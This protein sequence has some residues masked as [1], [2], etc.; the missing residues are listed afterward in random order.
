[1]VIKPRIKGFI[2]TT[3]HPEGCRRRVESDAA[4]ARKD[5][6]REGGPKRVLVIG[7]SSGYGLACRITAAFTYGADTL[8]VAFERPPSGDKT[9]SAG[10]YNTAA[11]D[12]LAAREGLRADGINGDAFS[13]E[14]KD[15]TLS[16]VKTLFPGG[17]VDMV[18]YSLAAPRRT[19]PSTGDSWRS[20][21]KP[22]GAPF[23]GKSV[24]IWTGAV[25]QVEIPPADEAETEATVKVMGGE[26]WLDWLTALRDANALAP[27]CC[28]VAFSYIGP[29]KTHAIYKNG[30]I[31]KAKEDLERR[32]KQI[33]SLLA[34]LSGKAYVSVNKA[35]VTQASAAIP[36]VPLYISLLYRV[37]KDA[38]LHEDCQAQAQRLFHRLYEERGDAAWDAVGTDETGR[39]RL[40]DWEMRPGIQAEVDA[41]WS[42]ADTDT[43]PELADLEGY[44]ADFHRI[45]GFG[46]DGVNY[47][48]DI[49][50]G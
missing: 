22:V 42:K 6:R 45:F 4:V 46:L 25:S 43:L 35:L 23:S 39:I 5:G 29:E 16:R 12:A 14:I 2:C 44:R 38:G 20:A 33:D 37:M 50:I 15:E 21:I 47:D 36:V 28:T 24:D 18:I 1:M 7:S 41:R 49:S 9:A 31:G 40:D 26:D 10:W 19:D 34:P 3:A 8:G 13:Q 32:A 17:Q 11:F 27:G 48:E 30:T